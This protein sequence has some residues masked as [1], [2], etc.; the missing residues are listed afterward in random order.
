MYLKQSALC[1]V[2][3]DF[4]RVAFLIVK[5]SMDTVIMM[6]QGQVHEVGF[7]FW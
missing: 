3:F 7:H 1:Q 5:E 2:L 4:E 6:V